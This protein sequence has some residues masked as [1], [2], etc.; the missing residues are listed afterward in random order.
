MEVCFLVSGARVAFFDP[1]NFEGK[2]G[3]EVKQ[4][5]AAE[6]GVTRFRQRLFLE[7]GAYEIPDDETLSLAV[8]KVALVLLDFCPP[9]LKYD[10]DIVLA[11]RSNDALALEALLKQPRSPNV[12]DTC[13]E[14]ALRH[15]ARHGHVEVLRLLLEAGAQIDASREGELTALHDAAENGQLRVADGGMVIFYHCFPW[16][17]HCLDLFGDTAIGI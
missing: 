3:K 2:T 6:I 14:T 7:D 17:I 11:A 16:F 5:L 4:A 1:E 10:E 9:D 12:L 15:A 13:G 8:V